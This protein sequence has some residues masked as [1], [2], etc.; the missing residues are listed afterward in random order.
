MGPQAIDV[1]DPMLQNDDNNVP[2]PVGLPRLLLHGTLGPE[3]IA[4]VRLVYVAAAPGE[5]A[6]TV[7]I[8]CEGRNVEVVRRQFADEAQERVARLGGDQAFL[9]LWKSRYAAAAAV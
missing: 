5:A 7:H 2:I 8:R 1:D 3:V 4:T 6:G 9:R